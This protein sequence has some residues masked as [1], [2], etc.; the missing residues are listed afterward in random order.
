MA[1]RAFAVTDNEAIRS[2]A[3]VTYQEEKGLKGYFSRRCII[4]GGIVY[5][6]DVPHAADIL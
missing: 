6:E 4:Y 3:V 2:L 5:D 1:A